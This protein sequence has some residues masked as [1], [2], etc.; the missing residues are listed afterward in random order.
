MRSTC[1]NSI[2]FSHPNT[3]NDLVCVLIR[4]H[5]NTNG[6]SY[7]FQIIDEYAANFGNN[8]S[9][10]EKL[11]FDE[12]IM[13]AMAQVQEIVD[14]IFVNDKSLL[15]FPLSATETRSILF[16]FYATGLLIGTAIRHGTP[17]NLCLPSIFYEILG[18]IVETKKVANF[19]STIN[20]NINN[21]M[22]VIATCALTMRL[23]IS[24]VFPEAALNLLNIADIR[25]I[26]TS[27]TSILSTRLLQTH[28]QYE[29]VSSTD[30]HIEIFW[31]SLR[32]LS[33]K[34]LL[35]FL[36]KL[37]KGSKLIEYVY[38]EWDCINNQLPAPLVIKPPTALGLLT[39]D[40]ADISVLT[41]GNLS[42]PR[43]TNMK[44]MME[45]LSTFLKD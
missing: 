28:A 11:I 34:G 42:I 30:S 6:D 14:I 13:T 29:G 17:I 27:T 19:N 4:K 15:S 1:T 10:M 38:Y 8:T 18:S 20:D 3:S 21:D 39:P 35:N 33:R 7:L 43:C 41:S 32:R 24:S 9:Y 36:K 25:L 26:L 16:F 37:W 22:N 40:D 2:F 23:G 31:R 12:F 45:K 44:L 5:G